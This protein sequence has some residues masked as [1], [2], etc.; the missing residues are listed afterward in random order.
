VG[1]VSASDEWVEIHN[2]CN[3]INLTGWKLVYRSAA[4]NNGRS[5]TTLF[6][7]PANI[8]HNYILVVGA[9]YQGAPVADGQ[10][11]VAGLAGTGGAVALLDANGDRVDSVA[12]ATLT[13]PND[14]TEGS[15]P[16]PNPAATTSIERLP[17]DTDTDDNAH[18]FKVTATP[19]PKAANK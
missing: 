11:M 6:T 5:D 4:N 14:F 7:F 2:P 13:A 1:G 3:G 10:W 18:D 19:T 9:G 16:A 17:N 12:Y 8:N 15:G